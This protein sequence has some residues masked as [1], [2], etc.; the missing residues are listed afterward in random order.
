MPSACLLS[1]FADSGE[2]RGETSLSNSALLPRVWCVVLWLFRLFSYVTPSASR[3]GC[4]PSG[5]FAGWSR[6]E[7]RGV[8]EANHQTHSSTERGLGMRSRTT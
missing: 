1:A 3:S 6:K 4:S 7:K 8:C 2:G 5:L